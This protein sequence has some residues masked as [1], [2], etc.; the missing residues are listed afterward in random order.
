MSI[1]G[2][3]VL[4]AK[5]FLENGELVAIP[6]E[7]VYGLA[8]NAFNEHAVSKIFSVKNRPSFDPL[9]VHTSSFKRAEYFTKTISDEAWKLAEAFCPGPVTFIL[10][11]NENISDLVTSGHSTVGV[12]V[13]K[14]P[15]SQLLLESLEFPLAAPSANPFGFVSPTTAEHV[16]NQLGDKIPMVLDGGPATVGVESTIIDISSADINILRLGGLAIE[17]IE[18]VLGRKIDAIKTSSSKPNAPGMLIS[19]YSPGHPLTLGPISWSKINLTKEIVG[20]LSFGKTKITNENIFH[21]SL[22]ENENLEE[23]AQN[24]FKGL[25]FFADK[26]VSMIYVEKLPNIGLGRAINDRLTRAATK[27]TSV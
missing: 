9:I 25:R 17:N 27:I 6:T 11:K 24:L 19:H 3:D 12:R 13:P 20:I 5:A 21:F 7:T 22:S 15:L 14:H 18:E 10:N 4:K 8:A 1:L 16:Q 26:N 2:T 23:A